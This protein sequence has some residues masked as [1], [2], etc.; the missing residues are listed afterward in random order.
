MTAAGDWW[1]TFFT[2]PM[3]ECWLR[4]TTEEQTRQEADFVEAVLGVSPPARLLDVPCGGGRHSREL[5]ARGYHQT[6]VDIS[7]GFLAAARAAAVSGPGSVAWERREMRDLPWPAAF[8]GALCLGNSFAYYDEA[9]NADFLRA[10]ARALKPGARFLL[11]TSYLTEGLLPAL[12]AH[13]WTRWGQADNNFLLWDRRYDPADGRLYVEYTTIQDGK[14]EK[15]PMS[16]RL[17]TYRE[18]GRLAEEAGFDDLQGYGSL[19]REPF[20]FGSRRLLL[21]ATRKG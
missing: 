11:D 19:A 3:V 17:Y 7:E 8:D 6:G 2:G 18:I 5:A 4:A 15:W 10:V 12:Q 20:V 21:V 13:D 14:A 16:A 1:R 9:R